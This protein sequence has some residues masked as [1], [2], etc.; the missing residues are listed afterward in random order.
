MNRGQLNLN[1]LIDFNRDSLASCFVFNILSYSNDKEQLTAFVRTFYSICNRIQTRCVCRLFE[2]MLE[3]VFHIDETTVE[4]GSVLIR[5]CCD[6]LEK[7]KVIDGMEDII[8]LKPLTI[9]QPHRTRLE[10]LYMYSVILRECTTPLNPVMVDSLAQVLYSLYGNFSTKETLQQKLMTLG[11]MYPLF[12][13]LHAH[14]EVE[15]LLV[16]DKRLENTH[17]SD[18]LA[19]YLQRYFSTEI[20][21]L[22]EGKDC[23]PRQIK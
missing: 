20:H 7:Y 22:L 13:A 15:L 2:F 1:E 19:T 10:L 21:S 5:V 8:Q 4:P 6:L 12:L 17:G 3:E 16:F 9:R 23:V 14:G 11:S 18:F